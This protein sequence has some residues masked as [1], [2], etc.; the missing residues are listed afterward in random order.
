M[1]ES[2]GCS[3]KSGDKSGKLVPQA[4]G[5]A[6]KQGGDHPR[7][8]RPSNELR[9]SMRE[10]IDKGLPELEEI[11]TGRKGKPSDAVK[12]MGVAARFGLNDRVDKALIDELWHAVD[13]NVSEEDRPAI[14]RAW[15]QIVGRR[16][17]EAAT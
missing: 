8:G 9:G 13:L 6:L 16:L 12:A 14:K 17:V 15:N 7:P 2:A 3:G 5:G 11:A 1:P 10:I 4:H